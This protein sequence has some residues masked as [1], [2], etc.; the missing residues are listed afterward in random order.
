MNNY[1]Q[2]LPDEEANYGD[3]YNQAFKY[4][5]PKFKDVPEY[6]NEYLAQGKIKILCKVK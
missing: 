2:L 3:A 4:W 5:H 6:T 1:Y